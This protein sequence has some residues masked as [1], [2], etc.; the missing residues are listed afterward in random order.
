MSP[1]PPW[2]LAVLPHGP[3]QQALPLQQD[4]HH[5]NGAHPATPKHP[6]DCTPRTQ[7]IAIAPKAFATNSAWELENPV[8]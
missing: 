2:A 3:M 5:A 8:M 6:H 7:A 1:S 4:S